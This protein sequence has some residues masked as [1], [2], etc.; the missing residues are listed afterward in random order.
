MYSVTVRR[1]VKTKSPKA[2]KPYRCAER[3]LSTSPDERRISEEAIS[4]LRLAGKGSRF[5]GMEEFGDSHAFWNEGHECPEGEPSDDCEKLELEA[6]R[7]YIEKALML[8]RA[9]ETEDFH[10]GMPE[11]FVQFTVVCK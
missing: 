5:S 6:C 1:F 10:L 11:Y 3:S 9:G 2:V 8:L 4:I 7:E